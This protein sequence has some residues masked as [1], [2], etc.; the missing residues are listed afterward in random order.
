LLTEELI[1]TRLQAAYQPGR[2][3]SADTVIGAD[4]EGTFKCAAVLL[5][6]AWREQEWHLVFTRRT[7]TV[8]HHKGQVSFPGG[9][10]ELDES[11]PEATA[12]RE[13]REEI[14]LQPGDVRLLGRMNEYL[15][16]TRYRITPVVGVI[17]WP[18]SFQLEEAEVGRVFSIPLLWLANRHN[19]DEKP[20]TPDGNQ[21]PIPVLIYHPFDGEILWGASARIT[22]TFLDTLGL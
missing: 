12:L 11:T 3:A 22:Q 5:P 10:C 18:Y 14:G 17:P 7:E 6:L 2:V 16:I 9:G 8:E 21:R 13:A 20:F 4:E 1:A 15:T 19:R